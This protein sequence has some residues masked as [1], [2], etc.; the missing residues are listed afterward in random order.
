MKTSWIFIL[1]SSASCLF[2]AWF[3]IFA[4]VLCHGYCSVEQ[5]L[6][7]L[8]DR[9][10][11]QTD[12]RIDGVVFMGGQKWRKFSFQLELPWTCATLFVSTSGSH[13][14][15]VKM[16]AQKINLPLK[17]WYF[18]PVILQMFPAMVWIHKEDLRWSQLQFHSRFSVQFHKMNYLKLWARAFQRK[19][20]A[21]LFV[22]TDS[23]YCGRDQTSG[24]TISYF[25]LPFPH[26]PCAPQHC[27]ICNIL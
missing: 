5:L 7:D 3:V 26:F 17:S 23:Q 27:E 20:F 15:S 2:S 24:D 25:P 14:N 18:T 19:G 12:L 4:L 16:N 1:G 13:P 21:L 22:S 10:L 11:R 6:S 8:L 9:F